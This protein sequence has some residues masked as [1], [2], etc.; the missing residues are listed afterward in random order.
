MKV[1]V[2]TIWCLVSDQILGDDANGLVHAS[3]EMDKAAERAAGAI[4]ELDSGKDGEEQAFVLI[5][6]VGVSCLSL[7]LLLFFSCCFYLRRR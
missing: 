7:A 4:E 2:K 5:A 3:K 1:C 6:F